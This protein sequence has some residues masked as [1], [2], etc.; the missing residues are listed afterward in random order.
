VNCLPPDH[1]ER[2]GERVLLVWGDLPFWV[3][4]DRA[5][6]RLIA[7]LA[8]GLDAAEAL[9]SAAEGGPDRGLRRDGAAVLAQLRK[10]GVIGNR[11]LRPSRE[12]IES[13]SVNVTRRCNLRCR[14]C[15]NEE[16][17]IEG[18]ELS[19]EEMIAALDSV[20]RWTAPG[21]ALALLGGEPLLEPEKTLAL[22]EWGRRRGLRPIVSTNGLL[23]GPAFAR[24]AARIGLDVQVSIDGPTAAG[25]EAVRG[26]GTFRRAIEAVELL[27]SSGARTI[28]SMVFH[29]GNA[30][31]IPKY[32][33]LARRLGAHEARFIPLKQIGGG[34]DFRPP[35]LA[36]VVRLVRDTLAAE[37]ELR[38]LLGR[39]YYSILA[40]TCQTCSPRPGCGTGSQTF[41]LDADGTVYP[42]IN[43]TDPMFAAGSVREDSLGRIW[44]RS[45]VLQDVRQRAPTAARP[46]TCG[47]CFVRHWCMGGC[48]GE[49]RA[50]TG[51]LDAPSATCRQHRASILEMMWTLA[52]EGIS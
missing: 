35:D 26:E 52:G 32:M 28:L 27:V 8:E 41:L 25:H 34:A 49:S 1:R 24:S 19:A 39:D 18:R 13:I 31:E 10:A 29:A 43:L 14:F 33:R 23:V 3:V 9:A 44:R 38:P 2:R 50:G 20:R 16:R 48:R 12:R 47:R 36:G 15:Y 46:E 21:A 45:V 5:A 51:R 6:D 42:C 7:R 30:G 4:V 22:G 17:G 11:R 37:P 40:Q